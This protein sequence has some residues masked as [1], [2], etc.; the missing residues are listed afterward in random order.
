MKTFI[1]L[2]LT[3]ILTLVLEPV[4]YAQNSAPA[5][6]PAAA[7]VKPTVPAQAGATAAAAVQNGAVTP[8]AVADEPIPTDPKAK[9]VLLQSYSAQIK[10]LA[11]T[12]KKRNTEANEAHKKEKEPKAAACN[13]MIDKTEKNQCKIAVAQWDT[14]FYTGRKADA[15]ETLVKINAISAK[16][17]A[18]KA[19]LKP[20]SKK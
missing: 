16:V 8:P 11:A 20:Q 5:T 4:G 9:A 19:T 15:D 1:A 2:T 3:T 14:E 18:I 12:F 17:K 6:S 13:A 7:E 10:E